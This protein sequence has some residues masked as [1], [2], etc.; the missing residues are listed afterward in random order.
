M[1]EEDIKVEIA[2]DKP[3]EEAGIEV[4]LDAK[5]DAPKAESE[6]LADSIKADF[7][8][9]YGGRIKEI[10]GRL[11]GNYRIT[12][13]LQKENEELRRQVIQPD[14]KPAAQPA[15]GQPQYVTADQ[16]EDYLKNRDTFKQQQDILNTR[17]S[18]MDESKLSVIT[19][20]PD[21]H[22]D[23][24]DPSS[25]LVKMYDQVV[26]ELSSRD[27]QFVYDPYGPVVAMR[28]M[29]DR[30]KE[31]AK[32]SPSPRRSAGGLPPSRPLQQS[33]GKVILSKD[34]KDFCDY[35]NIPYTEYAK[36]QR[37]LDSGEE[38]S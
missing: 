12:E 10:E 16:L 14:T 32:E 37:T 24:S 33:N 35:H 30:L 22:P 25:L 8:K 3:K 29:E 19:K 11:H 38:I 1:P 15:N 17:Q 36:T 31:Q 27:P 21:L 6:K 26:S 34:Q 28:E 5:P 13:R 23:R 20:Y 18:I 2:E 4:N 9:L 7:E